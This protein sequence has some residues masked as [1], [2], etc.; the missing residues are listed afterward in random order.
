M[1]PAVIVLD[2]LVKFKIEQIL[3]EVSASVSIFP[4]FNLTLGY[5][6]GVSFGIL[7]STHWIAPYLLSSF[8]V[9]L[10]VLALNWASRQSSKLINAAGIL[11]AAGGLANA[12][13]RLGDGAVTDYLD[14]GWQT[15]RWPTFNLADVFI[16]GG[17]ALLLFGWRKG[18]ANAEGDDQ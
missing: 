9:I 13:D 15:A 6:R 3:T 4:G 5:N 12:I 16:F 2:L 8:A 7:D 1:L 11:F 17:V 18:A 10:V 14:F